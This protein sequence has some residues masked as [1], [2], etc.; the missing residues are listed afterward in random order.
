GGNNGVFVFVVHAHGLH[1]SGEI[2]DVEAHLVLATDCGVVEFHQEA[3]A[4]LADIGADIAAREV[5]DDL[6]GV[7]VATPEV[8]ARDIGARRS[9][10]GEAGIAAG[11]TSNVGGITAAARLV[12]HDHEEAAALGTRRIRQRAGQVHHH[13]R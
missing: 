13:A 4:A 5:D 2:L 10:A 12:T 1:G 3:R 7:I 11:L 8:H 9:D 6:A